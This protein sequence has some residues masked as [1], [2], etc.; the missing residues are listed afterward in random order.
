M[1]E[2]VS[3]VDRVDRIAVMRVA[4]NP[5]WTATTFVA[6]ARDAFARISSTIAGETSTAITRS[7]CRAAATASVPVPAPKSISVLV[8]P[9][10]RDRRTATSAAGSKPALPSYP[11]T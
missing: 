1:M 8:G 2:R 5:A 10:P 6:S 9:S 11:A 4:E 7:Q 3:G